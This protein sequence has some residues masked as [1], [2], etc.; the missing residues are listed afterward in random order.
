MIKLTSKI[1][2]FFLIKINLLVIF[3]YGRSIGDQ[4]CISSL[5]KSIKKKKKSLKIILIVSYPEL[6]YNNKDVFLLWKFKKNKIGYFC[7]RL[8]NKI[9]GKSIKEF[10]SKH[11]EEGDF[12]YLK[13]IKGQHIIKAMS[14][15]FKNIINE[16][17][18]EI[19]NKFILSM[20]EIEKMNSKFILPNK[21]A[22]VQS[23]GKSYYSTLK[24]WDQNKLQDIINNLHNVKWIQ[25]GLDN[26]FK[27]ENVIDL[28]SKTSI[29]ELGYLF[30]RAFFLLTHEG[31]YSHLSSC[32]NLKTFVIHPGI[33]MISNLSYSNTIHIQK[34]NNLDCYPCYLKNNCF[35]KK[36]LCMENI[37]SNE[38]IDL[39][40][41]NIRL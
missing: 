3:R 12:T 25:I 22:L 17:E 40:K 20:S 11:P 13:K 9:K 4:L 5:T 8:L 10:R 14:C 16:N 18:I 6:F 29:R 35:K 19:Q 26:E 32:F 15:E 1:L 21:F 24:Q 33:S 7:Y 27:F 38:V 23:Q 28:R 41:K 34:I 31:F 37:T 39:I 30:S 2:N 36:Q